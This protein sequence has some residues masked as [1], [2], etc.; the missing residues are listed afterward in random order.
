MDNGD[1]T[2]KVRVRTLPQYELE[3]NDNVE[4]PWVCSGE[5]E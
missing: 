2:E 5:N 4:D 3:L 1:D